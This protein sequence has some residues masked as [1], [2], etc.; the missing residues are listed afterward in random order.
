MLEAYHGLYELGYAHSFEVW[1]DEKL[2]GGFY[3]E[4]FGALFCGESM[5][6]IESNSSSSAFVLF[7]QKFRECGGK[8]IDCQAYTDNMAR[9]GVKKISRE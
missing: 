3:G 7:A 2:V 5:F 1:H 8:M 4:L 9:Y 6:T